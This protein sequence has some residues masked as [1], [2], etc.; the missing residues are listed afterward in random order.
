[1]VPV[2]ETP[3]IFYSFSFFYNNSLH[4]LFYDNNSL[5]WTLL[6]T[7]VRLDMDTLGN[8]SSR[9]INKRTAFLWL[10]ADTHGTLDHAVMDFGFY[11]HR[12]DLSI[13]SQFEKLNSM[14]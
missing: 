12:L 1:M 13:V 10:T 9:T 7:T 8:C 5:H 6:G 11:M 4:I 3:D 2:L 14:L